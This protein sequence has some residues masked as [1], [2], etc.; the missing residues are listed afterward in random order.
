MGEKEHHLSRFLGIRHRKKGPS[1]ASSSTSRPESPREKPASHRY[2]SQRL[3]LHYLDWGNETAPNL[4]MIHGINDHCHSW[5]WTAEALR[6][7]FHVV[8][9]DLRGHGD[10]EWTLGSSYAQ[11]EYVYD[12]VHLVQQ[13][14]LSPVTVVGHS[15]G[16]TVAS[17]FAGVYPDLVH[18]LVLVEGIGLYPFPFSRNPAQRISQWIDE[19]NALSGR[20]PRRYELLE[21]AYLRMQ[22]TNPHLSPEQ[23]RHLTVHGSNQNEDGTFSW[24]FDNY[25]RAHAPYGIPN[26]DIIAI[27]KQI[28]CPTLI[29]NSSEGYPHRI[30]HDGTDAHFSDLSTVEI[31]GAGH[32]T[33]HDKLEEFLNVL[34]GFIANES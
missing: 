14:Q 7:R 20:I 1:T 4:L 33:H 28:T 3:R 21:D 18:K 10:S 29:I 31:G 34:S 32:W 2:F 27:W 22:E 13:R 5:D 17:I 9:P 30:G 16:G 26:D 6:D 19:T 12:I 23:A 24:K 11:V 8:V 25:T 15:M